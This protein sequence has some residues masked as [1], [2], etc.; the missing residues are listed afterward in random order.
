MLLGVQRGAYR[1]GDRLL[2]TTI[3]IRPTA[4]ARFTDYSL[5][6]TDRTAINIGAVS[7]T[8]QRSGNIAVAPGP[9]AALAEGLSA[10]FAA[11]RT[12]TGSRNIVANT[13]LSVHVAP[14]EIDAY[15]TGAEGLDLTGNTLIKLALQ[16]PTR[17]ARTYMLGAPILI[18]DAGKPL[19]PEKVTMDTGRITLDAARD[20]YVCARLTYTDRVITGGRASYDEGRQTVTLRSGASPW[21][22][23]LIVPSQDLETPLWVVASGHG[24]V[25]FDDHIRRSQL[26][27]DDPA[28]AEDFT[29]WLRTNRRSRL[30]NG[31]LSAGTVD[32]VDPIAFGDLGVRRLP[33]TAGESTVPSCG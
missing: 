32:Q 33:Q 1:P 22:P 2:A 9:V 16:L 23:F 11:S 31:D 4:G 20:L 30:A 29:R 18:D 15:R 28:A 12:Q 24:V 26:T 27:F 8:D 17:D 7:V 3:S 13:E 10:G 6:A 21:T 14:D 5:A 25:F 19:P